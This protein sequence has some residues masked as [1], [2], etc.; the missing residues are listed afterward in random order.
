MRIYL[1]SATAARCAA[2][3]LEKLLSLKPA[4]AKECTA[5]V[6]G[7]AHW[8]E[9]HQELGKEPASKSDEDCLP[10]EIRDRQAFQAARL[11][12]FGKAIG[13]APNLTGAT[14]DNWEPSAARP[15]K[16][17]SDADLAKDW[18][19]ASQ[20]V[21]F[22][23]AVT[24]AKVGQRL[25]LSYL[26]GLFLEGIRTDPRGFVLD[27]TY[28][29]VHI[30]SAMD[31]PDHQAVARRWLSAL[32]DRGHPQAR[33]RLAECLTEGRGG[34]ADPAAAA[35]L[36]QG[37][38]RDSSTPKDMHNAIKRSM[39]GTLLAA[40]EGMPTQKE[41][42]AW[43]ANAT[44]G[45]E[46]LAYRVALCYDPEAAAG[47]PVAP[48]VAKAVNFYRQAAKAG[49]AAAA[50]NLGML[51]LNHRPLE[52]QFMESLHWLNFAQGEG[53]TAARRCLEE[54]DKAAGQAL[55][56]LDRTAL[57]SASA[58]PEGALKA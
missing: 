19:S 25:P 39:A 15:K 26:E 46:L 12:E 55:R 52:E 1:E 56:A 33:Y 54:I 7:Y 50:R 34:P 11:A 48:D 58:L 18:D 16:R 38:L 30:Y 49:H 32:A 35:S 57:E 36:L 2:I 22:L 13:L 51:L 10:S 37:L 6:L 45:N 42:R 5:Y 31:D 17:V 27:E 20:V 28:E 44:S 9:L 53:D 4:L 47:S 14:L 40:N 41:L 23:S 43:E 29:V 21:H 3:R 24:G 8:H